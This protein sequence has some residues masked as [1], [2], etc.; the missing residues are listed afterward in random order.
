MVSSSERFALALSVLRWCAA[1]RTGRG[2][3]VAV[4]AT[5]VPAPIRVTRMP[6]FSR[7]RYSFATVPGAT[8]RSLASWRTEGMRWSAA[9][10][11]RTIAAFV[12]AGLPVMLGSLGALFADGNRRPWAALLPAP[13]LPLKGVLLV[14]GD[15]E[16]TPN[17]AEQV[18]QRL[19]DNIA[20]SVLFF[21]TYVVGLIGMIA[22]PMIARREGRVG[23]WR[24]T[25]KGAVIAPAVVVLAGA[26]G[27]SLVCGFG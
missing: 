21:T 9:S 12:N 6:S 22:L 25:L 3:V 15:L 19:A 1:S 13:F 27:A 20:L 16:A 11:F 23:R 18:G 26:M 10:W 8:P 2:M 24:V 7:V 5:R 14:I 17:L 4:V